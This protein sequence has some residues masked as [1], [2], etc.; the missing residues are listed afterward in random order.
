VDG[1]SK[2]DLR[3]PCD[4]LPE[5]D[6]ELGTPYP[7]LRGTPNRKLSSIRCVRHRLSA[8]SPEF[9]KQV[10]NWL[11]D[12][13]ELLVLNRL[14]RAAGRKDWYFVRDV[15]DLSTILD[16]LRPL[17][18]LTVYSGPQLPYRGTAKDD[19]TWTD[20]LGLFAEAEEAVFGELVES[21]PQLHRAFEAVPG[22]E[23]WVEE[24]LTERPNAVIVFGPY[25]PFLDPDPTVALD[26]V[27]PNADGSLT[28]GVY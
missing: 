15:S 24:W 18:C 12:N 27:L 13:P 28:G 23:E 26:A 19:A 14:N 2:R 16:R 3:P 8:T 6:R 1:P 11:R 4:R 17:D 20:A 10:S 9:E 25:P 21:D 7:A 22:D 5:G